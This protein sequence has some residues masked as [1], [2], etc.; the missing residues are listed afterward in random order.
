MKLAGLHCSRW[1][2]SLSLASGWKGATLGSQPF[3]GFRIPGHRPACL[4]LEVQVGPMAVALAVLK[5]GITHLTLGSSG[6]CACPPQRA[7]HP[8]ADPSGGC[9]RSKSERSVLAPGTSK[10]L[11]AALPRAKKLILASAHRFAPGAE[12]SRQPEPTAAAL[13]FAAAIPGCVINGPV[14]PPPDPPGFLH[15]PASAWPI[16]PRP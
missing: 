5:S 12:R 9:D 13:L 4:A 11:G 6:G 15:P 8:P 3:R 2:R 1:H 7:Q 16:R 14:Q 10:R